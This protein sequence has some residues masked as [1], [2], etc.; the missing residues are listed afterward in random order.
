MNCDLSLIKL[1]QSEFINISFEECKMLGINWTEAKNIINLNFKKSKLNH[2]SFYGLKLKDLQIEECIACEVDF[3]NTEMI[4][5]KLCNSDLQGSK[6]NN[7][8]LSGSD[9]SN[10]KNYYLNPNYNKITKAKFSIPDVLNL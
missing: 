5:A 8:N 10:A 2:S 6:F 9:L 1:N 3:V 7:T 4:K